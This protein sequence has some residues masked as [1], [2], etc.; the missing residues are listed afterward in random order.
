LDAPIRSADLLIP[1]EASR[2][3]FLAFRTTDAANIAAGLAA[4]NIIV[5]HRGDRLRIGFGIYHTE[6]DATRLAGALTS[7]RG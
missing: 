3:R 7:G 1:N 2:G 5:D 4:Q 6:E